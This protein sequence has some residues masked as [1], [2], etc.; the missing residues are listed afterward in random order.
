MWE[1]VCSRVFFHSV[2]LLKLRRMFYFLRAFWTW[3]QTLTGLMRAPFLKKFQG[4][5]FLV[6]PIKSIVVPVDAWIFS[7]S[8]DRSDRFPRCREIISSFSVIFFT[9]LHIQAQDW[10]RS[11]LVH[12]KNDFWDILLC[13]HLKYFSIR[14]GQRWSMICNDLL[15]T[16]G[17]HPVHILANEE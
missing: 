14:A 17:T 13:L 9:F 16:V 6:D 8:L 3:K 7:F 11:Y 15:F 4:T 5:V 12:I 10:R 1:G 2:V